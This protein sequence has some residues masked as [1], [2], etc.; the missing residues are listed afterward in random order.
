MRNFYHYC[1][2]CTLVINISE[3]WP[4]VDNRLCKISRRLVN[5]NSLTW[6]NILKTSW[7]YLCKRPWRR[8]EDILKRSWRRFCKTSDDGAKMSW[9]CL[10][11]TSWRCLEDV[12]ARRLEDVLKIYGQDEYIGLDQNV[13]KTSSKDVWL[14]QIYSS[15]S[16]RLED[17]FWRRRWR[18]LH[19]DE[20]LVG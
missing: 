9:K 6:W 11:K 10:G 12:F 17:V 13:L 5:K 8:L 7:K 3:V 14:R 1:K 18:R 19:Q 2:F 20:C 15:W 4:S 16:R